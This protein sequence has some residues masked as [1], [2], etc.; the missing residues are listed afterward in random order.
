MATPTSSSSPPPPQ[1]PMDTES[2]MVTEN[3]MS[4]ED[5][6]MGG[7]IQVGSEKNSLSASTS[8]VYSSMKMSY[9]SGRVIR[10]M[11]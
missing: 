11:L 10:V 4:A 3:M 8:I 9:A 5:P 1:V 6:F 2:A 7:F